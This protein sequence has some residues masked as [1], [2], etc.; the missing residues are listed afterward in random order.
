MYMVAKFE[1]I[2]FSNGIPARELNELCKERFL[3]IC[4]SFHKAIEWGTLELRGKRQRLHQCSGM[5]RAVFEA[6]I[7]NQIHMYVM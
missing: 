1:C 4:A 3:P 7:G 6:I 5:D 2:I